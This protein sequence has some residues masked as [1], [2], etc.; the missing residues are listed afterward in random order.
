MDRLLDEILLPM[1]QAWEGGPLRDDAMG[2]QLG[3]GYVRD[4][5]R[6]AKMVTR[7]AKNSRFATVG[8]EV[9]FGESGGG[10][11]PIVLELPDGRRVALRGKID[12]LDRY[13]GEGGSYLRVIDYKS[14]T[15]ALDD[16]KMWHGLQLQLLLYLKA[17][18][19]GQAG[20][21]PAGAFYFKVDDPLVSVES[22]VQELAETAIA[23]ALQLKGITLADVEV[24]DAMDAD[25]PGYSLGK[26]KKKDGGFTGSVIDE[27]SFGLLLHHAQKKASDF[28]AFIRAGV[29]EASPAADEGDWTACQYCD[30][31]DLCGIDPMG[32][33]VPV[34]VMEKISREELTA[35][36]RDE[37][38]PRPETEN[39][40]NTTDFM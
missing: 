30:Y 21:K 1:T 16:T 12:R 15:K 33:S 2:R 35:R 25:I 13:D 20:T 19:E 14:S 5:R 4:V 17:A 29:I 7:Q 27:E 34:R 36:L 28:A 8:T 3:D 31:A 10:L 23:K 39:T 40:E 38:A 32:G 6:A 9:T 26:L 37:Y 11:P 24:I 18:V 22:D